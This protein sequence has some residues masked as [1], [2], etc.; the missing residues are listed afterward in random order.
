MLLAILTT[1][2]LRTGVAEASSSQGCGSWNVVSSPNPGSVGWDILYGVTAISA[3]NSWSVGFYRDGNNIDQ[4]LTEYWDGTSWSVIPSP[5]NGTSGNELFGV[6]HVPKSSSLW[7]VGYYVS[8]T[9]YDETLAEHWNGTSWSIVSSPN[10]ATG[11][12]VLNK[13]VALSK[14][15]VW[16]V[17]YETD[18]HGVYQTLIEHWNGSRWSVVPS[19]NPG[20]GYN[21][22]NG[23]A[24]VPGTKQLWAVGSADNGSGLYQTLIEY[25]DGTSWRVVPSPNPGTSFNLLYGVTAISANNVWA[26]GYTYDNSN[27][28]SQTLIEH[29]NGTSWSVVPSPNPGVSTNRVY[30]IT[31]ISANNVWA[32]GFKADTSGSQ[33]LTEQWNGTSWSVVPSPNPGLNTN[34]LYE[35]MRVPGTK[36]LWTVGSYQ[37]AG[38]DNQTLTEFHC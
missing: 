6:A 5:N 36:H 34:F 8:S 2:L 23:I 35:V 11:N 21:I 27:G 1:L 33:T 4:T 18:I 31:A 15:N 19:P 26:G 16:A 37:N 20:S 7:A 38:N 24:R 10:P 29:W 13:V 17:G 12:N 30:G 28:F 22:L 3:N 14:N 9:G 25:W 32:V